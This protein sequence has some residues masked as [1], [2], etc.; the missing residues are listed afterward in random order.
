MRQEHEHLGRLLRQAARAFEAELTAQLQ[1][2]GY[3]D[4]RPGHGAVFANIDVEG[5]RAHE[6]ARRARMTRP[7]MTQLIDDLEAKGYVVRREDPA[8]RRGRLVVPTHRGR[9]HLEEAR[10]I[11]A[12]IEQAYLK[13][14]GPRG[15]QILLGALRD[16]AV[17]RSSITQSPSRRR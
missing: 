9:R 16:L 1:A 6:L 4:I 8:D 13:R 2:R 11:I 17:G 3:S 14:L 10:A 5:T 15:G 7:S 12:E